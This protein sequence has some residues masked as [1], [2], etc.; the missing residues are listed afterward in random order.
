MGVGTLAALADRDRDAYR[1]LAG[2]ATRGEGASDGEIDAGLGR[3]GLRL[4]E[5]GLGLMGV[6]AALSLGEEGGDAI[7][8]AHR[9]RSATGIP[10]PSKAA[11]RSSAASGPRTIS[12]RSTSS[13][14]NSGP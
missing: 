11:R 7:E 6:V 12:T 8:V 1:L 14:Q 13:P 2:L 10:A 3:E 4:G 5:V 9:A